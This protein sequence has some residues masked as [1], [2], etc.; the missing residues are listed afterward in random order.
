V[1]DTLICRGCRRP[2]TDEAGCAL[3]LVVKPHLMPIDAGDEDAVPLSQLAAETAGLL[4]RQ[5]TQLKVMQKKASGYDAVL[6]KESREHAN[7]LS[8]LMDTSRKVIQDGAD[9]V[10]AMSFAEKVELFRDW[11]V[12]LP[13][14]YRR[15]TM[16]LLNAAADSAAAA[17]AQ[18]K[19]EDD[20]AAN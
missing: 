10:D 1:S 6:A 17:L 19:R 11:F 4:R 5:L 7:A 20:A 14:A 8:K 12:S 9:A 2:I 13:P 16:E 3:C 15:R 18:A